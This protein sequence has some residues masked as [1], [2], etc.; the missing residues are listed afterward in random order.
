MPASTIAAALE[1][2]YLSALKGQRQRLACGAAPAAE[3]LDEGMLEGAL[4][5]AKVCSYA[6]GLQLI[7][8]ASKARGWAASL[9]DVLNCWR[10]GCI[11]RAALL[12]D[13]RE[14][15]RQ[16]AAAERPGPDAPELPRR[17]EVIQ[18]TGYSGNN[19]VQKLNI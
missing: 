16:P 4:L 10:G 12:A 2:R 6:Q 8:E 18:I 15:F 5:C 14:A 11:I 3:R 17:P 1:A 7:A 13:F 9:P 19:H